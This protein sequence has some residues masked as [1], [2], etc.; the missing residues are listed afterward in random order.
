MEY[1]CLGR[2][3]LQV[4]VVGMGT[5]R[6]FDVSDPAEA[7]P[8]IDVALECGSNLFDSSPMYGAAECVLGD[9][10]QASTNERRASDVGF[11]AALAFKRDRK[12][13]VGGSVSPADDPPRWRAHA[14]LTF[15]KPLKPGTIANAGLR[16]RKKPRRAMSSTLRSVDLSHLERRRNDFTGTPWR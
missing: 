5:Y 13:G 10:D 7:R 8:V 3:G 14:P 4:P 15:S 2:S 11:L 1:R 16:R 9:G 12:P 6:T